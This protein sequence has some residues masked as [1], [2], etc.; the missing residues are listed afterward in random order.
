V[1]SAPSLKGWLMHVVREPDGTQGRV[2]GFS[3]QRRRWQ[4]EYE[5]A[6]PVRL[7]NT[8]GLALHL[9]YR[10]TP[11][12]RLSALVFENTRLDMTRGTVTVMCYDH[13]EE[14]ASVVPEHRGRRPNSITTET[15]IFLPAV[16]CPAGRNFTGSGPVRVKRPGPFATGAA[17]QAYP[18]SI[19]GRLAG[20]SRSP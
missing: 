9:R 4:I 18:G 8:A 20:A 1:L 5:G 2:S 10:N 11:G 7:F 16:N 17:F 19:S 13:D 6:L 12:P 14:G 3:R 15:T